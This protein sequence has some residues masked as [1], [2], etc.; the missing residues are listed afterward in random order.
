MS[1]VLLTGFPG[2]LGS[3]LLPKIPARRDDVPAVCG[4]Q[5]HW[6][7]LAGQR[8]AELEQELAGLRAD[9][10]LARRDDDHTVE[11]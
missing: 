2:F 5:S 6:V 7:E 4:V 3:A 8:L 9:R 11:V 10:E 1:G